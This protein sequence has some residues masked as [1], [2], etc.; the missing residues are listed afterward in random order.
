M[1][2]DIYIFQT[3]QGSFAIGFNLFKIENDLFHQPK[4]NEIKDK[5]IFTMID[6]DI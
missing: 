6:Q 3:F 4:E 5:M 2:K 1:F